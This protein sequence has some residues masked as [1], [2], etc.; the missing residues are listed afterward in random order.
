VQGLL[1]FLL[2]IALPYIGVMNGL[3]NMGILL[4]FILP[5]VSLCMLQYRAQEYAK[6][7]FTFFALMITSALEA[8]SLYCLADTM[9][10]RMIYVLPF[11]GAVI[12]GVFML[13]EERLETHRV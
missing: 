7:L 9:M 5:F 1:I 13:Q 6:L 11:I 4:S 8:Y 10:L 3:C 12:L 2:V